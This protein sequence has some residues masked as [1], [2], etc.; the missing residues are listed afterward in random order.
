MKI[1]G[2]SFDVKVLEIKTSTVEIKDGSTGRSVPK[3]KFHKRVKQYRKQ[4]ERL[5]I[6]NR[7]V[8]NFHPSEQIILMSF[9]STVSNNN[10]L[11]LFE[12]EAAFYATLL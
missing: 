11:K 3:A 6:C 1:E 12:R 5:Y 2:N 10:Y 9:V 8:S 4:F 7:K